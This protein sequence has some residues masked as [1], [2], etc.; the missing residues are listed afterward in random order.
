MSLLAGNAVI[1][2]SRDSDLPYI[3][4]SWSKGYFYGQDVKD[5]AQ[6]EGEIK[7]RR[8][9]IEYL[10]KN[11]GTKVLVA[12]LVND[13]DTI[14]G[15]SVT[16]SKGEGAILHWVFVRPEWRRLGLARALVYPGTTEVSHLTKI[17]KS[18]KPAQWK[19]TPLG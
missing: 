18:L 19:Y 13:P 4:S 5:E 9:L 16:E 10:I 14:L 15:F 3:Y 8:R 12:C 1:R 17:G 7:K 2:A 11:P 6:A